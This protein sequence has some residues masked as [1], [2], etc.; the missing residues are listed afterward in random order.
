MPQLFVSFALTTMHF[1]ST[2]L[3][4]VLFVLFVG[5]VSY[6]QQTSSDRFDFRGTLFPQATE[7]GQELLRFA[8]KLLSEAK[9]PSHH[10]NPKKARSTKGVSMCFATDSPV[11]RI[12]FQ[13]EK[14]TAF[15]VFQNGK[16]TKVL[17]ADKN[18]GELK[19]H[20]VDPGKRVDYRISFP[21]LRNPIFKKLILEDD[22]RLMPVP[23]R[24]EKVFV[25]LGDSITHGQGQTVSHESWSWQVAE[26]LKMEHYN[27]AVGG[28]NANAFM[29]TAIAK[30]PRVDLVTILWGYNDWVNKGKKPSE[31]AKDMNAAVDVIRAVHPDA[32]IAIMRMLQTKTRMSKRTGDDYSAAD[33]RRVADELVSNR[34][35][36]GDMN[37]H[38]IASETMTDLND[39]RDNV[40]LTPE[41]ATNLAKAMTKS[42]EEVIAAIETPK[43]KNG[44]TNL[45]NR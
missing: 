37:I 27:L 3:T 16:F 2:C 19:I 9:P 35:N 34:H 17:Y 43:A 42:L 20:S 44:T 23:P 36:D 13:T 21:V 38:I 10:F 8:P 28:S 1:K 7:Q 25:A 39:L 33:F 6:S 45:E 15:G 22:F 31:F 11:V 30:L 5:E 26:A 24:R 29:P 4:I 12:Q 14:R 18:D 32:T 41:G 40:H